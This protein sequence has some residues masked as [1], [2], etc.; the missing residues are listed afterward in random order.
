M[1]KCADEFVLHLKIT[2][3]YA[4]GESAI[5][6]HNPLLAATAQ[7]VGQLLGANTLLR[8]LG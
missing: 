8:L 4:R 5:H 2:R 7:P 1:T 3:S 6:S